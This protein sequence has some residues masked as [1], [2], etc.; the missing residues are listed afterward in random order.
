MSITMSMDENI[1]NSIREIGTFSE[2]E[3]DTCLAKLTSLAFPRGS[4]LLAEGRVCQSL[5]F[6]SQGSFKH[7]FVSD[8]GDE[9]ILD[10]FVEGDWVLNYKSFTSQKPSTSTIQACEDSRVLEL[11]VYGLHSLI[12]SSEVFFQLGR[13]LERG[14]ERQQ[15][16][17]LCPSPMERY[18]F[19]MENNPR[20]IQKFPLKYIASYLDIRPETLS[21]V[22]K[23]LP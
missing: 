8:Q 2:D 6:I 13:L 9:V 21:R 4:Q 12:L 19:L 18:T 1:R 17:R 15:M 5:C 3:I 23:N 16:L 22:R 11:S 14:G 10:L 20:L 7:Y